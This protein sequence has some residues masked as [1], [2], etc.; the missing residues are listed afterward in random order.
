MSI[1]VECDRCNTSYRVKDECGGKRAKCPKCGGILQIPIVSSVQ[2]TCG[3][4]QQQIISALSERLPRISLPFIYRI[5]ALV[6]SLVMVVLPLVYFALIALVCYATYYHAVNHLNVFSLAKYAGG[7]GTIVSVVLYLGPLAVGGIMILFMIKPIFARSSD[8][9]RRRSVTPKSDPLLFAFV[10]RLCEVVGAP[11]PKRIDIDCNVNASASFRRG[12]L[13]IF[14]ANDLVLTIGL[15]L[16]AGLNLRQFAGILAHEFGHFSQGAGMRLTYI[17]R[18]ISTWFVRVVYERDQWDQSLEMWAAGSN[19]WVGIVMHT[20]RLCV[21]LS[22]RV[23]WILMVCGHAVSGLLLRQMEYDADRQEARLAGS[24]SFAITSRRLILLN[25]AM[26]GALSDIGFFYQEGRLADNL[27]KL[28]MINLSKMPREVSEMIERRFSEEKTGLFDTHPCYN[29]RVE[30]AKRENAPGTFLI[31]Q[32]ATVL[33]GDFEKLSRAVTWDYYHAIFGPDFQPSK[34]HPLDDLLLRRKQEDI[35]GESIERFFIGSFPIIRPLPLPTFLD[36]VEDTRQAVAKLRAA[37]ETMQATRPAYDKILAEYNKADDRVVEATA[38]QALLKARLKAPKEATELNL[39]TAG[40]AETFRRNTLVWMNSISTRMKPFEEAASA[41]LVA[42]LSL[43]QYPQIGVRLKKAKTW[44]DDAER[45]IPILKGI[46]D[47]HHAADDLRHEYAALSGLTS[48]LE[49][50]GK[51]EKLLNLIVKQMKLTHKSLGDLWARLNGLQYPFD[52]VDENMSVGKCAVAEMPDEM[53][54]SGILQ[55][56]SSI[57]LL[58][59]QLRH[60]MLARLTSIAEQVEN[61]LDLKP[62]PMPQSDLQ[63]KPANRLTQN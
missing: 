55:A 3:I 52:H 11:M 18:T 38:G 59:A 6:V 40:E 34:M 14:S 47:M 50:N 5:T 61:A 35:S 46:E 22:R 32:P 7:R 2:P 63:V 27:P 17:I 23:L 29:D 43:L 44:K 9:S 15:P 19:F 12:I 49:G 37:R 48:Q 58:F 16:I 21:W 54:L 57:L 60:R 26:N 53:N 62:L 25:A 51:N 42:D 24:D 20:A 1:L 36:E 8:V 39:K 45:L 30:N 31:E 41:R 13:S 28:V 4:T 56:S 10:S 33:F